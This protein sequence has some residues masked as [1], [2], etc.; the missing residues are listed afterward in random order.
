MIE[1]DDK[2]KNFRPLM[3]T[4]L[5]A[6]SDYSHKDWLRPLG[7]PQRK[8]GQAAPSSRTAIAQ[9]PQKQAWKQGVRA[10]W[11]SRSMQTEQGGLQS[12]MSSGSSWA[13]A[14][15]SG[16][17]QTSR[18]A[19]RRDPGSQRVK[20]LVGPCPHPW[21]DVPLLPPEREQRH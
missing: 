15:T 2:M 20:G 3:W 4:R 8:I 10:I 17:S 18:D 1:C 12:M 7:T 9:T 11:T 21:Q 5:S 19:K 13:A 16:S 6:F 14:A